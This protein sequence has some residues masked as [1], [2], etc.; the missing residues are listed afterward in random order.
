MTMEP[1]TSLESSW[2]DQFAVNPTGELSALL[3]GYARIF[4]LDRL[5]PSTI[6]IEQFGDLPA[7]DPLRVQLDGAILELLGRFR[8]ATA[9]QAERHGTARL[10]QQANEMFLAAGRLRLPQ[11][12]AAVGRDFNGW[13][14]WAKRLRL[15]DYRDARLGLWRMV[16]RNQDLA[17]LG[18][19]LSA[20]WINLCGE[21]GAGRLS[22]AYLPVAFDGLH[23]LPPRD[24]AL[25][26]ID[27]LLT[28][29]A[30]WA[31]HLTRDRHED[32][33]VVWAG[34]SGRLGLTPTDIQHRA[35]DILSNPALAA[36][37][38]AN[39]WRTALGGGRRG[40]EGCE[41]AVRQ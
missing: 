4:P 33:L 13:S 8:R 30:R 7:D 41:N 5:E 23:D 15:A 31:K 18:R 21:V 11:V 19:S 12:L 16:A 37:P 1:A 24:G 27:D 22:R 14:A 6:L 3:G 17:G 32:F 35:V 34:L 38:F 25:D 2:L 40:G 36:L 9:Q 28:G 26:S 39:W 20:H 10:I 29:V